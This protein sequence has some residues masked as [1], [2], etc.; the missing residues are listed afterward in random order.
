MKMVDVNEKRIIIIYIVILLWIIFGIL[1]SIFGIDYASMSVYFL[2]LTGF[3]S[4]YIWGES[5]RKSETSSI[6][7]KGETSS[8]ERMMYVVVILWTLLGIWGVYR[9]T[10]FV[11]IAAYFGSLTP[12]VSAYILGRTYKPNQQPNDIVKTNIN[13][14]P[15]DIG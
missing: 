4:A 14:P 9:V 13:K 12:F 10:D 7:K 5:I 2:S 15:S 3:V 8:R 11:N 6:F 1:A